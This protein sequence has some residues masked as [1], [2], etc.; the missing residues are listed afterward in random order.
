MTADELK[1][2]LKSIEGL[3]PG[4]IRAAQS[5]QKFNDVV[6][7]GKARLAASDLEAT[8][9]ASQ[10]AAVNQQ[11][12]AQAQ[13][14]TAAAAA[15]AATAQALAQEKVVAAQNKSKIDAMRA[16][17][18]YRLA[19]EKSGTAVAESAAKVALMQAKA[20]ST[21]AAAELKQIALAQ[22]K[23]KLVKD[24]AKAGGGA[25]GVDDDK[26]ISRKA[27]LHDVLGGALGNV[28]NAAKA[29][30]GPLGAVAE[31]VESM[32]AIFGR[33][34]PQVAVVMVAITALVTV[35]S[36]G[37]V[38]LYK[39]A[40]SAI[41][42][43]QQ[44]AGLLATFSALAGGAGA[45]AKVLAVVDKLSTSLPFSTEK[46]GEWAK[47]LGKTKMQ[48]Q[49]LESAIKAV[50]AAQAVMGDKGASA[51]QEMITT[52]AMGGAAAQS[53]IAKIKL[54]GPEARSQLQEMGLRVEDLA[55]ALGMSVAQMKNARLSAKQ[56]AEALEKALQK[57]GATSLAGMWLSFPVLA[58]KAKEGFLSLFDKLGP[59]I[60]PFMGAVKSLFANFFKGGSVINA[61][62]PIVTSV[63]STLFSWATKAVVAVQ[64][65]LKWL[66]ASGKA[67]GMFS[68]VVAGM[69]AAWS[70][71]VAT[72]GVVKT[73]LA[74]IITLLKQIF[75]NATVLRGMRMIFTMIAGAVVAVIVVIAA[76]VAT[77]ATIAGLVAGAFGAVVGVVSGIVGA[78]VEAL[79]GFD[80]SAFVAKMAG[81][82]SAGLAAFKGIFGIA[83]PS[84]VLMEHGEEDMAGG[85]AGGLDAG[86]GKVEKSMEA[87]GD[88]RPG[89]GK[90]KGGKGSGGDRP[91]VTF[92]GCTFGTTTQEQIESWVLMALDKWGDG[93]PEPEGA[94]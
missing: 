34:P 59:A 58:Q 63:M 51:A 44:R 39:M 36:A 28:A 10:R 35:A 70:V 22:K 29:A 49:A 78:I 84:K 12:L 41:E 47:E 80:F 65:I 79:S 3:T 8:A 31:K 9:A 11:K 30:G 76:L 16:A 2:M 26:I 42:V 15:K 48:G 14:A 87:L 75:S 82:A 66:M 46:I 27:A 77:F 45:G 37:A 57:K 19:N 54:G 73:A 64:A 40:E 68:G 32:A 61:L 13:T 5:F 7:Q 86:K 25:G 91:G 62:K 38:A 56:M 24:A 88:A 85:V 90:G 1:E 43:V 71:L 72:F 33:V 6:A 17:Q 67:G 83:S 53:L 60:K 50:A 18:E 93:G 4:A 89:K 55:G 94:T 21:G 20:A 92:S 52:L 74:P 69:K 81:M 23:E